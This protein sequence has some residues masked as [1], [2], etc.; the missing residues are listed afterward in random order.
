MSD[1][2]ELQ[3]R[4]LAGTRCGISLPGKVLRRLPTAINQI[5]YGRE[6]VYGSLPVGD[7]TIVF[8]KNAR[9]ASRND[10]SLVTVM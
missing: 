5:E 1:E 8:R 6:A 9:G 3:N 10:V 7:S 4:A 2:R